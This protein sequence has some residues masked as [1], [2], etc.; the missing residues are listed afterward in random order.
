MLVQTTLPP[1][2]PELIR[3]HPDDHDWRLIVDFPFDQPGFGPKDDEQVLVDFRDSEG[4]SWT[5]VWLP[6]F[7]S[8]AVQD[9]LGE[10]VVLGHVLDSGK[11]TLQT[12]V[13]HL[14]P[15]QRDLALTSM[16]NLQSQKRAQVFERLSGFMHEFRG[17]G[18]GSVVGAGVSR[19]VVGACSRGSQSA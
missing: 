15:E 1:E 12:Y 11:S 17:P 18:R 4:G 3:A 8:K 10:L 13:G 6:S 16:R 2:P 14:S 7:S 9:T 5:L 19:E